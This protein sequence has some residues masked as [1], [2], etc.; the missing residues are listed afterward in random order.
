[1]SLLVPSAGGLELL[2]RLLY[3]RSGAITGATNAT[4]AVVTATAHGLSNG[5]LVSIAGVGGNTNVNGTFV[6]NNVAAN[7][8]QIASIA[9]T[10]LTL[11]NGNGAY[12]SGG[13]WTIA[14]MEN[15]SLK[16]FSSNTPLAESDVAGTYTEV[17]NGSGY[18]TG[19]Q[20]LASVQQ[21]TGWAIP[22]TVGSGGTG[23][24]AQTGGGSFAASTNVPESTYTQLTWSWSGLVT[25]YGYIVV[26]AASTTI[27]WAERFAGAPKS[28]AS[29][30]TLNLTPRLG[31][32][33]S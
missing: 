10:A 11:I 6:V 12:T 27:L 14:P 2:K 23:N 3:G 19:G 18:T 30:D 24:W 31:L 17:A 13:T 21:A 20:S 25:A 28:F 5:T 7:T 8:F 22:A 33:H 16:L 15:A 1:M 26:G 9:G 32:T 29:G 4:P